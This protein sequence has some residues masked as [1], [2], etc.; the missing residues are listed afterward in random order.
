M[1]FKLTSTNGSRR[2]DELTPQQNQLRR[3][4]QKLAELNSRLT[5][6]EDMALIVR[7]ALED[8]Q[9]IYLARVSERLNSLFLEMVG[10]DPASMAQLTEDDDERKASQVIVSAA[11]T[12]N[13]E[14]VVNSNRNTT[15]NPDHELS[16]AQKRALTFAFIWA[17]TE[18]SQVVAPRIIDTPLGMMSGLVKRRVLEL[19]TSPSRP[20]D[21]E[22]QVVL[23]LTR[24]EIRGIESVVDA[25]A[26][27]IITFTNSDH[28]PVDVVNNPGLEIP[29]V[30]QCECNHRQ[31]CRVCARRNDDEY[32]LVERPIV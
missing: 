17:L 11:I 6:T 29:E 23:F 27:R 10:A 1:T 26:G 24:D 30:L 21:V 9:Q 16:G 14:I 22:K 25:R 13:Y 3:Q 32:G 4:D 7:G 20:S 18:V 8:L 12:S 31:W 28:Y 19:I 2:S 5:V 15:L